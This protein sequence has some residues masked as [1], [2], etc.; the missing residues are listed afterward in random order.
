MKPLTK[1]EYFDRVHGCLLAAAC[2]DA[3]GAPVETMSAKQIFD[4]TNGRGVTEYIA[5]LQTRITETMSLPAGSTTDDTQLTLSVADSLIR[6]GRFNLKDQGY[7]LVEAR[8][9][10]TDPTKLKR[11]LNSYDRDVPIV[12]RSHTCSWHGIGLRWGR[13]TESAAVKIATFIAS[14][15]ADG[16]DPCQITI[17]EPGKGAGNGPAMK[18]APLAIAYTP[19]TPDV[20]AKG[21]YRGQSTHPNDFVSHAFDLAR[22]THGEIIPAHGAIAIGTAIA[23]MLALPRNASPS[24]T[25]NKVT[26]YVLRFTVQREFMDQYIPHYRAIYDTQDRLSLKIAV[27]LS[28]APH[29]VD[30]LRKQTGCGFITSES[31]PFALGIAIRN[32]DS[33]ESALIEAVNAGGDTDTNAAMAGA[34]VGA[35]V[36]ATKIPP[37]FING[38]SK[39]TRIDIERAAKGL[40]KLSKHLQGH[41]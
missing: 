27:G 37:R 21:T 26:N 7:S 18:I 25:I 28:V 34:I 5:P 39:A 19:V 17:S 31:V 14:R 15:G 24:F 1:E 40:V 3:L 29:S 41:A 6:S 20:D 12:D 30:A 33:V 38:L 13:T 22:Q 4:A 23:T 32:I 11:Y 2:G 10:T 8:F 16:R 35:H 9:G 36:G